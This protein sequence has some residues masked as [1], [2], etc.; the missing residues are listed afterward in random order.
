[1]QILQKRSSIA[2][3]SRSPDPT[4]AEITVVAKLAKDRTAFL[5]RYSPSDR[6]GQ[7][8]PTIRDS[9]DLNRNMATFHNTIHRE[10]RFEPTVSSLSSEGGAKTTPNATMA[11]LTRMAT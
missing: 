7:T 9:R 8:R 3:A 11:M 2:S 1:M 4:T 10:G 6:T 5:M